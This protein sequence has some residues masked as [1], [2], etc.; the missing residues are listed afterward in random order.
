MN[1]MNLENHKNQPEL[2]PKERLK[3]NQNKKIVSYNII[4]I[5]SVII[6]S[7][8]IRIQSSTPC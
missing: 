5:Q 8:E 6:F 7:F 1:K 3:L 4:Q 2:K